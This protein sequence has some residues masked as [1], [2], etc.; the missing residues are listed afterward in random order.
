MG[1]DQNRDLPP[2]HARMS[3][4]LNGL[5]DPLRFEPLVTRMADHDLRLSGRLRSQRL[6]QSLRVVANQAIGDLK[7]LRGERY[8]ARDG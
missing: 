8:C 5:T 4:L 2:G 1:P 6:P 3:E 7:D